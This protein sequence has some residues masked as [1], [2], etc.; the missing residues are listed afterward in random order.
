MAVTEPWSP[1]L[2]VPAGHA[3]EG[4]F[5]QRDW[6]SASL[7]NTTSPWAPDKMDSGTFILITPCQAVGQEGFPGG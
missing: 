7:G 3:V 2:V 5:L 4:S 1:V 6:R